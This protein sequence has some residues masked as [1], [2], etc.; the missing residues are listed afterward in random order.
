MHTKPTIPERLKVLRVSEKRRSL[1]ELS[2]TL[3]LKGKK[4]YKNAT[5][6]FDISHSLFKKL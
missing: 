1:Q 4:D 2:P 3:M 6:T 5:S